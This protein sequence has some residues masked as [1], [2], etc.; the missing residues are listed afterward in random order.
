MSQSV[1]G[2]SDGRGAALIVESGLA[3][4]KCEAMLQMSIP[5]P[6]ANGTCDGCHEALAADRCFIC[7]TP[8]ECRHALCQSCFI[9]AGRKLAA[10]RRGTGGRGGERAVV[11]ATARG[12]GV[13]VVEATA[14]GGGTPHAGDHQAGASVPSP[15]VVMADRMAAEHAAWEEE[16]RHALERGESQE[17]AAAVADAAM[18]GRMEPAGSMATPFAQTLPRVSPTGGAAG[19]DAGRH[20]P[21]PVVPPPMPPPP[22]GGS[23]GSAASL[24]SAMGLMQ[25][26]AQMFAVS[27]QQAAEER[28]RTD[29][30]LA[31]V[32]ASPSGREVSAADAR[33]FPAAPKFDG[34]GDVEDWLARL[35][36]W[37]QANP[38]V[39]PRRKGPLLVEA[40][41]GDAWRVVKASFPHGGYDGETGYADVLKALE[42]A[43]RRRRAT[44]CFAAFEALLDCSRGSRPIDTFLLDWE[45]KLQSAEAHG[46]HC[47]DEMKSCMLLRSARLSHSQRSS[48]LL[49]I[50]QA[51]ALQPDPSVPLAYDRVV[52]MVRT[53]AQAVEMGQDTRVQPALPVVGDDL[54]S[55][56]LSAGLEEDTVRVCVQTVTR[57]QRGWG[58]GSGG[59]GDAQASR[60]SRQS[61]KKCTHCGMVGHL[62]DK[63]W[64]KYPDLNPNLRGRGSGAAASPPSRMEWRGGA[65]ATSAAGGKGGRGTGRGS[66]APN[67]VALSAMAESVM[68][69]LAG[70][71]GDKL[72]DTGD[73]W[74]SLCLEI[75]TAALLDSGARHSV[76]GSQWVER[77][78]R[79]VAS[80]GQSVIDVELADPPRRYMF[81]R[82]EPTAAVARV[83]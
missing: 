12:G 75:P 81:G 16:Y 32:L 26:M 68:P 7:D 10:L 57:Q 45:C 28:R 43:F 44:R 54:Q 38:G 39:P 18:E 66:G 72:R 71:L 56:L 49:Q 23:P 48:L 9:A 42:A 2:S 15:G 73:C 79:A 59:S 40:L 53:M 78:R 21:P 31:R 33:S 22:Q 20:S 70:V 76:A 62:V 67:P 6:F 3:C 11:G 24:D 8:A 4:P 27:Q 5:N 30:L 52:A 63:C 46:M 83:E 14:R 41:S 60:T 65:K 29:E 51:V 61:K 58:S 25:Q 13:Q 34:D 35:R 19:V 77:Y 50:E 74:R 36:V 64:T 37:E 82:G 69:T 17:E 80:L 47:N 55:V 1:R